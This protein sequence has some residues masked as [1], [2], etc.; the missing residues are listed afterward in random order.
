MTNVSNRSV[1]VNL[2]PL[3]DGTR[4][5]FGRAGVNSPVCASRGVEPNKRSISHG[6]C[7][8]LLALVKCT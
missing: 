4:R 5:G 7:L 8:R 6:S 3:G 2:D 1:N